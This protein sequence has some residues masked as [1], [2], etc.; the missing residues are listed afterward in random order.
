MVWQRRYHHSENYCSIGMNRS[1][2]IQRL[3]R[4]SSLVKGGKINTT[5]IVLAA[6]LV[7]SSMVVE[8]EWKELFV[9]V[10]NRKWTVL[11]L[12]P[13]ISTQLNT[14]ASCQTLGGTGRME[15]IFASAASARLVHGCQ[16]SQGS[17]KETC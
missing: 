2:L 14:G 3:W 11:V 13:L 5:R 15:M 17:W 10:L 9:S 4:M 12:F 16:S 8:L 6:P 1:S 7:M